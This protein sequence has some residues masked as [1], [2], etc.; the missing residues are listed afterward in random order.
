MTITTHTN[1][2]RRIK[3]ASQNSPIA[4]FKVNDTHVETLFAETV[5]TRKRISRGCPDYIGTYH[6]AMDMDRVRAEIYGEK[7]KPKR[8]PFTGVIPTTRQ[9]D[10]MRE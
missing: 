5:L 2:M 8:V 7:P 10:T 6:Q 1:A 9:V 4:V 3:G